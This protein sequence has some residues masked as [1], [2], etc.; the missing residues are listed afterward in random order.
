M[1][2]TKVDTI[3]IRSVNG[4]NFPEPIKIPVYYDGY[5]F[6]YQ[7]DEL[8]GYTPDEH[9]TIRSEGK[10]ATKQTLQVIKGKSVDAI[11]TIFWKAYM[12]MY[13]KKIVEKKIISFVFKFNSSE[14][15]R[16]SSDK[17][18]S[19]CGTPALHV[20]YDIMYHITF[21][22]GRQ[23]VFSHPYEDFG[24]IV[25]PKT[26]SPVEYFNK[27]WIDWTEEREQFFKNAVQAMEDM[28]GRLKKFFEQDQD[29]IALLVDSSTK[30]L[31]TY[32]SKQDE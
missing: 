15:S 28:I 21:P 2:K 13:S 22:D 4:T 23:R 30:G 11:Q 12:D 20:D 10:G 26:N 14:H 24:C 25:S 9:L 8:L 31:L 17:G 5:F 6:A 1:A 3:V 18:I 29:T 7:H 19:F 32:N 16:H 27:K